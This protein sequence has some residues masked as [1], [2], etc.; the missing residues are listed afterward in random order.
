MRPSDPSLNLDEFNKLN[1]RDQFQFLIEFALLAPSSHN[2]QPWL[3]KLS[4]K[5]IAVCIN[6]NRSL[7]KSDPT[8]RQMYISIGAAIQNIIFAAEYFGFSHSLKFVFESDQ[9]AEIILERTAADPDKKHIMEAL[10]S[11]HNNRFEFSDKSIP[12]SFL[13]LMKN[14]ADELDLEINFISDANEKAVLAEIV[15]KSIAEAFSDKDFTSELSNWIKPSLRKYPD[16]MPGYNIDIPFFASFLVPFVIRNFNVS[17]MQVKMHVPM[18]KKAPIFVILSSSQDDSGA[19][20]RTGMLF[21]RIAV[22][23]ESQSVNVGVLA[24]PIEINDNYK[25]IK[26]LVGIRSRPQ[27]FF[28]IGYAAKVPKQSP[29]LSLKDVLC[30]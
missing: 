8:G 22:L 29:R 3:F 7:P 15:L 5:G 21:E 19:W 23:A 28:R 25:K 2:T 4:E 24:A 30:N 13:Q 10:I 16:G 26:D 18:L 17:K 27:M 14:F 6:R 20:V 1:T 9:V 11:R 12:D